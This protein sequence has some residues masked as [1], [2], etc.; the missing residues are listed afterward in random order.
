M[1][2]TAILIR[3]EVARE[4]SPTFSMKAETRIEFPAP[5]RYIMFRGNFKSPVGGFGFLFGI[6]LRSVFGGDPTG[7]HAQTTGDDFHKDQSQIR[8]PKLLKLPR[9][10]KVHEALKIQGVTVIMGKTCSFMRG[11]HNMMCSICLIAAC[12]SFSGCSMNRTA[13]WREYKVYCGM[14]S[15]NGEVSEDAWLCFCDKYV[16]AAFP[17]GYTVF[18]AAGYWRSEQNATA[19]ERAKIIL[20]VAPENDREKVFSVAERYRKQFHQESVLISCSEIEAD[21]VQGKE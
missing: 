1:I 8:S 7:I 19:K 14:S 2:Q 3:R 15:R 12:L 20:I 18:D 9:F 6:S 13:A 10:I 4:S 11:L 5:A 21:F 17:G 16:S